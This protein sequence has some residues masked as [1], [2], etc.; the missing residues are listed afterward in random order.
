MSS[1]DTGRTAGQQKF[2]ER[3]K[4][5]RINL[6]NMYRRLT[7]QRW[8]LFDRCFKGHLSP[9]AH[10]ALGYIRHNWLKRNIMAEISQKLICKYLHK[11]SDRV[12]L[13]L[14]ELEAAGILQI[15]TYYNRSSMFRLIYGD[16][17]PDETIKKIFTK[18]IK[19]KRPVPIVAHKKRSS[20]CTYTN[21]QIREYAKLMRDSGFSDE[22]IIATQNVMI[23]K[24]NPP[25]ENPRREAVTQSRVDDD[26]NDIINTPL[27]G[28]P[29]KQGTNSLIGVPI[30]ELVSIETVDQDKLDQR[31]LFTRNQLGPPLARHGLPALTRSQGSSDRRHLTR[32]SLDPPDSWDPNENRS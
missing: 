22:D 17:L 27:S 5:K 2:V 14:K 19:K 16:D 3:R 11:S 31:F 13:A 28:S 4:I 24:Q 15:T 32:R 23:A 20:R 21:K 26:H 1:I 18:G 25:Q 29:R 9:L 10:A 8:Y 6:R 12:R 7:W 30:D